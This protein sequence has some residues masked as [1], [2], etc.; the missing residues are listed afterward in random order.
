[1][2]R[3]KSECIYSTLRKWKFKL[4]PQRMQCISITFGIKFGVMIMVTGADMNPGPG[5]GLHYIIYRPHS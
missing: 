2:A 4:Q 3:K 5:A 1:M